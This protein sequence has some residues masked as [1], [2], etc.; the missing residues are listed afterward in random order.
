VFEYDDHRFQVQAGNWHPEWLADSNAQTLEGPLFTEQL[1]RYTPCVE[2]DPYLGQLGFSSFKSAGQREAV[3]AVLSSPAGSTLT[4][5]LPTGGGKSLCGHLPA[6]LDEGAVAGLVLVIVPTIALALDQQER[7]KGVISHPTAYVGGISPEEK[8]VNR[9]IR[10]RIRNGEQR[11]IFTSPE[12]VMQSLAP[13]LYRATKRGL[14]KL[15]V[16]DEAHMVEHW[17]DEFRSAFQEIAAIRTDLLRN[18]G[19]HRFRT[20]LLTA[21]LTETGLDSL[22]VLFGGPG[23]FKLLSAAQLRPEPAFWAAYCV[24]DEVKT[25]RVLEAVRHL[26]RPLILYTTLVEEANRWHSLLI[27]QGFLRTGLMTGKSG[28]DARATLLAGWRADEI[29]IV[30][31]TSAFGLG[32]DK[33]DVRAILHACVPENLDRYYQEVGRG[34]RDGRAS[35]S[36]VLYTANDLKQ[37]KNARKLIRVELGRE[38]WGAMVRSWEPMGDGRYRVPVDAAPAYNPNADNDYNVA[39]NLRT[40][41]LMARAGLIALDAEAPPTITARLS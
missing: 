23:P 38:R 24:S 27:N 18:S 37:A 33:D 6:L 39:W 9:A 16:V 1:R 17:G 40:L 25:S 26:P 36:L 11:I 15:F 35:A 32:V 34:G 41:T 14:L 3:R 20:L 4:I 8:A 7:L 19:E 21:T 30:V 10:H 13:V 22:E 28:R 2:P 31:A 29:D 12:S 5:L